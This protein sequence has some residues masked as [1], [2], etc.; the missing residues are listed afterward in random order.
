MLNT[1][2]FSFKIDKIWTVL[3]HAS[4]ENSKFRE[5]EVASASKWVMF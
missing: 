5:L 1:Y 2:C 3:L 4:S